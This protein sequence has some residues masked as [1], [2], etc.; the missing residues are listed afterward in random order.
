MNRSTFWMIKY[1]NGSVFSKARY[2][3]GVGFEILARTP[4]PKLS[5]SYPHSYQDLRSLTSN[6]KG[7]GCTFKRQPCQKAAIIEPFSEGAW[8]A[9]KQTGGK[10]YQVFSNYIK[11]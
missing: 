3:N 9:G 5:L 10:I 7:N 8:F 11:L 2:M 6:L 4:V 1:T